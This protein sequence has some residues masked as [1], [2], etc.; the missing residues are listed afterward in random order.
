MTCVNVQVKHRQLAQSMR[1]RGPFRYLRSS[2]ARCACVLKNVRGGGLNIDPAR[3]G[4][5]TTD[6]RVR[7]TRIH[8]SWNIIISR[9]KRFANRKNNLVMTIKIVMKARQ[10]NAYDL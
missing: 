4:V 5:W 9:D 10:P 7:G 3:V 8:H 1:S 2:S 6:V